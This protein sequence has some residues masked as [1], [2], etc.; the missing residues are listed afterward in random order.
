ML[1][2]NCHGYEYI[3]IPL[4]RS[5]LAHWADFFTLWKGRILNVTFQYEMTNLLLVLT[6]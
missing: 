2:Y 3:I 5:V 1:Y 4:I 6:S